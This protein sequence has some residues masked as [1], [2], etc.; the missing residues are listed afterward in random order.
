M[1]NNAKGE[2]LNSTVA[3][4]KRRMKRTTKSTNKTKGVSKGKGIFQTTMLIMA[5]TT[6]MFPRRL[7][8]A[9]ILNEE[10]DDASSSASSESEEEDDLSESDSDERMKVSAGVLKRTGGGRFKLKAESD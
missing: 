7:D 3:K 5:T 10:K 4:N 8:K 1:P 2:F 9:M 6:Q